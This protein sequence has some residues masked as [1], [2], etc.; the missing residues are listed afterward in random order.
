MKI[1]E[2]GLSYSSEITHML[3]YVEDTVNT[4]MRIP[5]DELN[6]ED[7]YKAVRKMYNSASNVDD[8]LLRRNESK[9]K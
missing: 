8:I 2:N 5:Y 3:D 4:L 7:L 6:D 1:L 9:N